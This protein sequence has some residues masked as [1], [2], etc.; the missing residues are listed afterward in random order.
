[1]TEVF[2]PLMA[3]EL[4]PPAQPQLVARVLAPDYGRPL[5][6]W[7]DDFYEWT[8]THWA[9]LERGRISTWL[10]LATER[11]YWV[12]P[13]VKKDDEDVAVPWAPNTKRVQEVAAALGGGGAPL[14]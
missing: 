7:Q 3:R 8:G 14:R 4:P 13:A 5:A 6:W 10:R 9:M 11:A 12:K 2:E 1:M